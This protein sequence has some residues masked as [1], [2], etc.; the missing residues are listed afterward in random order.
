MSN[1]LEKKQAK[2]IA[3]LQKIKDKKEQRL[4][5][6]KTN[7]S[8]CP[9]CGSIEGWNKVDGNA[10]KGFSG[11]KAVAGAI[12]LGPVGLAAGAL[13]KKADEYYCRECGF[14]DKRVK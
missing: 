13:G 1:F 14:R 10:R 7:A 5:T 12:V 3:N 11:G 8:K 9:S 4:N 6:R 2:N